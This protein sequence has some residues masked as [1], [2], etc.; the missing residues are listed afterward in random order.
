MTLLIALLIIVW[1]T[2][3]SPVPAAGPPPITPDTCGNKVMEGNEECDDGNTVSGD[4]CDNMCFFEFCSDGVVQSSRGEQCDDG[5]TVNNDGCNGLCQIEQPPPASVSA[6]SVATTSSSATA[7]SASSVPPATSSTAALSSSTA[8]SSVSATSSFA[9]QAPSQ[10]AGS[11]VSDTVSSTAD[12]PEGTASSDTQQTYTPET[13]PPPAPPPPSWAPE[14]GSDSPSKP[15]QGTSP[16]TFPFSVSQP[17]ATPPPVVILSPQEATRTATT[18]TAFLLTPPG[19]QFIQRLNEYDHKMLSTVLRR[20]QY[21]RPLRNDQR[22]WA[23]SFNVGLVAMLNTDR[24]VYAESM[25]A[26]FDGDSGARMLADLNT[27]SQAFQPWLFARLSASLQGNEGTNRS[28]L[29]SIEHAL[30]TVSVLSESTMRARLVAM[31]ETVPTYGV[32]IEPS[33]A[34]SL[35]ATFLG[36]STTR[37]KLDAIH[38]ASDDIDANKNNLPSSMKQ[39]SVLAE[40]LRRVL[41]VLGREYGLASVR[42]ADTYLRKIKT[43]GEDGNPSK[44][45]DMLQA[46]TGFFGALPFD[47]KKDS[48]KIEASYRQAAADVRNLADDAGISRYIDD[49]RSMLAVINEV[50]EPAH[51]VFGTTNVSGQIE[52]LLHM[53]DDD[54]RLTSVLA[55][56]DRNDLKARF[57]Q[58]RAAIQRIGKENRSDT[59]CDDSPANAVHCMR[60]LA[61]DAEEAAANRSLLSRMAYIV[62]SLFRLD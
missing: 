61:A 8:P 60:D 45:H 24:Q 1:G 59:S 56:A 49:D 57:V 25:L 48:N 47:L 34:A 5:N 41:P 23:R 16:T 62:R 52:E 15:L 12:S 44:A 13:Q 50:A 39:L 28:R 14:Q 19:Q 55:L 40:R 46:T 18:L 2:R 42:D 43:L 17:E 32:H 11:S 7:P 33:K 26:L 21:N 38:A 29:A 20:E 9:S 31:L 36:N 37:D 3:H 4:G 6:S 10:G 53:L 30:S 27:D 54:E 51:D 35:D 58:L 22:A